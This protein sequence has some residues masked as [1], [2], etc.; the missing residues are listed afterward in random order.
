ME[1][2]YASSSSAEIA[3]PAGQTC[4]KTCPLV[5]IQEIENQTMQILH[6]S[7]A[8][9]S[10]LI[11]FWRFLFFL[12]KTRFSRIIIDCFSFLFIYRLVFDLFYI[13]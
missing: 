13:Y 5:F 10:E 8:V 12:I 4:H 7:V 2:T 3:R 6:S 1:T 11:L 9:K